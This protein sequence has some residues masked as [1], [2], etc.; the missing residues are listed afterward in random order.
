MG[1]GAYQRRSSR[2]NDRAAAD[3]TKKGK[4]PK[5]PKER[6][7]VSIQD[8]YKQEIMKGKTQTALGANFTH[9]HDASIIRGAMNQI[10]TPFFGIHD[11]MY[12]PHGT[13]E[14]ACKK[15]RLSFYS[16]VEPPALQGLL[17]SNKL[18]MT[19]SPI[20]RGNADITDC[21]KSPYMFS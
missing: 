4:K 7:S 16:V 21:V 6:S 19:E 8:G 20:P 12:A 13:L 5:T 14:D 15:L 9:S 11:C 2:S 18:Q 3:D 17:K 1:G 10:E